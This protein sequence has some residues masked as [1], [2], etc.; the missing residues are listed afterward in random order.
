MNYLMGLGYPTFK[1]ML[2]GDAEER[3]VAPYIYLTIGDTFNN[4]PGYFDSISIATEE[5]GNWEIDEGFQI[6][7]SFNV[8]VNF[9]YI[10]KYLPT[11]LGKHY[12]VP[13]LKDN[14][15]GFGTF[16]SDPRDGTTSSPGR[17]LPKDS[18]DSQ[19]RNY[20]Q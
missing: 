15:A 2:E 9:V 18:W 1:K 12:E 7:L 13:W 16:N 17:D 14:G 8:T 6:P 5:N 20:D 10:G 19:L 11:A 3:P 4:T